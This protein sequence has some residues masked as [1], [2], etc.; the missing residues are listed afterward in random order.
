MRIVKAL[1]AGLY[2][3]QAGVSSAA[4]LPKPVTDVEGISEY[5]LANGL[6]VLLAPDDSKPTTTVNVTYRVGSRHENYGET[7]MAHLLEHLIFKGTPTHR[8]VWA[9]FSKRGLRANGSTWVDRTNY[10]ASFS[11][12]DDNLRWYLGWQADAMINS[13][14]ARKDLDTEMTVVRNEMEMGENDPG[15]ILFEKTLATMYQWHNYGKSTIGARSDVENVDIGR[16]QAFYRLYYQPDNATLIVSGKFDPARTMGWIEQSFGRIPKPKRALPHL[17][18]ID[19]V[20]D[21]ERSVTLR[22]VGG[23]PQVMLGYHVPAGSHPDFPAAELIALIVGDSP[24]GRAHKRLVEGGIA[25]AVYAEALAMAEPGVALFGAQFS[26]GQD[27]AR[28]TQELIQVVEGL[29]AEPITDEEFQ[30][31]Q[32]K[33]LKNWEQ[34]YS[35]PEAIGLVL[36]E[37]VAQGDWRLLFLDRD[38]VKALTRAEVQRVAQQR[39]V[40]SNR[41][42][43]QYVPTDKPV[44]APLPEQVDVATQMKS[45]KPQ[46][47]ATAV[48]AFDSSP[49]NID[50]RTQR[51]ALP[52][53]MK[54]ALL[55]KPTR[56]QTVRISMALR[57]GAER[58]LMGLR[59]V[60][61]FTAA[62]IDKGGAGLSR[63]QIQ[64]R[65]DALKSELQVSSGGDEVKVSMLSHRDTVAD[66]VALLAQLLRSPAFPAS[67]LDELKRQV[68]AEIQSQRDDPQAIVANALA[69]RGDPYPRG[70]V[71]H[72]RSFDERLEDSQAVTLERLKDFHARFYGAS[73]A[74]FAAV[75]DFDAEALRRALGAG[76]GDWT[77]SEAVTRVPRPAFPMAPGRE[78]VS[79]PDK[80]N[81]T[82]GIE[83]HLP[84]SD[85]DAVH[86][87]LMLA[88]FMFGGGGDSRLFKRI[89]EREGLSYDVYSYLDWGDVDAHTLWLGGAI[90]A[91][92]NA[93]KV[94]RAYREELAK[95]VKDGFSEQEVA[96]AKVAL[97]NYRRLARAQDDRLAQALQRNLDL[98]RTFAFAGRVDRALE[99]LQAGPVSQA[100]RSQLKPEQMAFMLAGDF[101]PH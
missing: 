49:A 69:R 2:V 90:F 36:S 38:R 46:A 27:P 48:A 64:D 1:V 62:M 87:A 20:Q 7:G 71:R 8:T 82:L 19:P 4:A 68:A 96:S 6:Q 44:R 13:F 95:V 54:V 47:A 29:G 11:A 30:R 93:D 26:A 41:T 5:R 10:F 59:E 63:V 67:A 18:T 40:T 52:N 57:V 98:E 60:S 81:A 37:T 73:Q 74:R 53:G 61:E 72:A 21:G 86:P 50:A 89:R 28:G 16:L 42:L 94:E 51:L 80:Q 100:L 83:L 25:S 99:G 14:I 58:S 33:W 9:E 88:N 56:G 77:A 32:G 23:V 3:V 55:P 65:L 22:R 17:Y 35:N 43:A 92:Q 24:A 75:G 85:S 12:N 70:D 15:R 101:K 66:A 79:T 34:Q 45:F 78:V 84:L 97:L 39:F 76:F 31:A 91:P